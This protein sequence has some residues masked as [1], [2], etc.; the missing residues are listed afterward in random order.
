[1]AKKPKKRKQYRKEHKYHSP[2]YLCEITGL[3]YQYIIKKLNDGVYKG[4]QVDNY[5]WIITEEECERIRQLPFH[6]LRGRT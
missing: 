1:M 6:D 3:T 2:R 5:V 4:Q